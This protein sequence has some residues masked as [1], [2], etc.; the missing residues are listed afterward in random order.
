MELLNLFCENWTQDGDHR[1][2]NILKNMLLLSLILFMHSNTNPSNK[3][4]QTQISLSKTL[5]NMTIKA[6]EE[7]VEESA[8]LNTHALW[9]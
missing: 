1:Y 7:P 2:H 9:P 5:S 6:Q 4:T 3:F 8:Q